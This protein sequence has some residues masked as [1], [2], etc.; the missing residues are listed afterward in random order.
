VGF[1]NVV[2]VVIDPRV[3]AKV[4]IHPAPPVTWGRDGWAPL[5]RIRDS[6]VAICAGVN[7]RDIST[8]SRRRRSKFHRSYTFFIVALIGRPNFGRC[9][10]RRSWFMYLIRK[11]NGARLPFGFVSSC[12]RYY[13]RAMQASSCLICIPLYSGNIT[14]L[15]QFT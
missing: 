7:S 2:V 15:I 13:A 9:E 10:V 3:P 11:L 8:A 5:T 6:V 14:L 1:I 12:Q 4:P